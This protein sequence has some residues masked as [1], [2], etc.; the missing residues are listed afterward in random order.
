MA[1]TES[2]PGN[3]RWTDHLLLQGIIVLWGFTAILGRLISLESIPLVMWRTGLAAV[4]LALLVGPAR[5][6]R[7]GTRRDVW[8][9]LGTGCLIG[10]HWFL[11]F[12]A[13]RL[14]NV[15]TGLAGVATAALWVA[16][17][18]PLLVPGRRLHTGECVLA[19]L[20]AAGVA[21]IT[22]AEGVSLPSFFTGVAAAAVAALFSICNGRL[23]RRLP[24][25]PLTFYELLAASLFAGLLLLLLPAVGWLVP[26]PG[27]LLPDRLVPAS[28]D[29]LPMLILSLVCTVFAFSAC[30]WLQRRIS[31][32]TIGLAGNL[33]PV[34]GMLL[35]LLFFGGSEWMG[36]RFYAG[37]AVIIGCVAVHAFM[38]MRAARAVVPDGKIS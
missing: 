12:L 9:A 7:F 1:S 11:F 6:R 13:G 34:Y 10:F 38:G 2:G 37:A 32:F 24:P 8:Q 18:E 33:E 31:A 21:V 23:V 35:A 3:A 5:L 27:W 22:G 15:S 36:P 29:W 16:L 19:I 26:L 20:V 30:V 25:L 4:A 28:G 17:L 14:G